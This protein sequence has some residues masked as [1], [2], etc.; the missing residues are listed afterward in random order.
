MD[1]NVSNQVTSNV[2]YVAANEAT[3][4]AVKNDGTPIV[5]GGGPEE[6]NAFGADFSM[7]KDDLYGIVSIM[8]GYRQFAALCSGGRVVQW[9]GWGDDLTPTERAIHNAGVRLL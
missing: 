3:M 4:V 5:W 7:V 9:S 8:S 1:P 6:H 2:R